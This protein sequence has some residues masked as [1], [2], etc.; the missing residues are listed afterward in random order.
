MRSPYYSGSTNFVY[1]NSNGNANNNNASNGYGVSFG[2]CV[3]RQSSLMTKSVYYQKE[4][5]TV[6][7]RINKSHGIAIRT[8]LALCANGE[9]AFNELAITTYI[10][11]TE[12]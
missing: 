8:L 2:F 10:T 6:P 4:C 5:V 3:C 7:K 9:S 12:M 11:D 1:V